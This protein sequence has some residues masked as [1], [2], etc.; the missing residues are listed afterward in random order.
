MDWGKTG[1][2]VMA[3]L[4]LVG[5]GNC[6]T[7]ELARDGQ[8]AYTI[9]TREELQKGEQLV[10]DDFKQLV[11]KA[12]GAR[13][14]EK[15][16]REAPA[17]KRIFFGIAPDGFDFAALKDQEYVVT[18]RGDDLYLFGGGAS[19]NR[20]AVYDFLEYSLGFRF[21]DAAGGMKVPSAADCAAVQVVERRRRPSFLNRYMN[22]GTGY[23]R[24][25]EASWFLYRNGQNAFVATDAVSDQLE[26]TPDDFRTVGPHAHSIPYYIPATRK[27]STF[28]FIKK[29]ETEDMFKL[30]PEYF[31]ANADGVRGAGAQVCFSQPGLRKLLAERVMENMRLNPGGNIFDMSA[32][33][34]PGQFCYCPGCQALT[35]KYGAVSG[36]LVDFVLEYAPQIGKLYPNNRLMC[37]VY[38]KGQ[39]QPPPKG[40]DKMPDNFMPDFAPIDDNFAK[41]WEHPSNADSYA[42]LKEWCRLC[43]D[44]TVWYYP[45]PYGGA[46]T[47][48]FGNVLRVVKDMKLMHQAG[49]NGHLMEHNVG[50]GMMVG[51]TELQSYLIIHLMRDINADCK[52]LAKEFIDHQYGAAAKEFTAYWKE[53]EQIRRDEDIF[54]G[55]NASPAAYVYL[56]P[57]R[58]MRWEEAFDRM[59][60]LVKD[61]PRRL[62]NVQRVRIN[63]DYG[64]MTMYP[65]V[66]KSGD[67]RLK[68]YDFYAKRS[69]ASL[70]RARDEFATG[71][72]KFR[73][74]SCLKGFKDNVEYYRVQSMEAKIGLPEAIFGKFP[75]ECVF[76]YLPRVLGHNYLDDPAAAYGVTAW[77]DNN[78][79]GNLKFPLRTDFEDHTK[80]PPK[81]F[82]LGIATITKEMLGPRGQ[83]KFY[84]GGE[85]IVSSDCTFRLGVSDAWDIKTSVGNTWKFGS[86][87]RVRFWVSLKFEGPLFYPEDVGKEN[88]IYCDRVVAVTDPE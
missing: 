64:V 75:K 28:A 40:L 67:Q 55:W 63:L 37:L 52:A 85:H 76:S 43:K 72:L 42:D 21:F 84:N 69:V 6:N 39:T 77:F 23:Y 35:K 8:S 49:V 54:L 7:L 79:R 36:P 58:L 56:T 17:S 26:M 50:V 15:Y 62:F 31:T 14:D 61:D 10:I 22:G 47:P 5:C 32:N 16:A 19:G 38:R 83:Y 41:D 78:G 82:T 66:R 86:Y 2:A 34:T 20:L 12:S 11:E 87:N 74:D 33:D 53:L 3:M 48:P 60:A 80:L 18:R 45:N 25:P 51:F 4:S 81:H 30:H 44:V 70:T 88:R 9:V 59:E 13:L 27:D 1:L 24:R 46:V 68:P 65:L 29:T 57:E 71:R 73:G